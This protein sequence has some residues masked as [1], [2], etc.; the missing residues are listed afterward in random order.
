MRNCHFEI[1]NLKDLI[2]FANSMFGQYHNNTL[3][4]ISMDKSDKW[5]WFLK[6]LH[7]EE[8]FWLIYNI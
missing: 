5:I 4:Y 6:I 8:T 7:L 3:I 2:L 1:L